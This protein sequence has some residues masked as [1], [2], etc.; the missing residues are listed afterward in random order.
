[1]KPHGVSGWDLPSH[2]AWWHGHLCRDVCVPGNNGFR[3]E[4]HW[5]TFRDTRCYGVNFDKIVL[6]W[7]KKKKERCWEKR[8]ILI[9]DYF[10]IYFT[11]FISFWKYAL[12]LHSRSASPA[13]LME[14][15]GSGGIQQTLHSTL[16]RSLSIFSTLALCDT[17]LS[18]QVP[19]WNQSRIR[20]MLSDRLLPRQSCWGLWLA[21]WDPTFVHIWDILRAVRTG[22]KSWHLSA[23]RHSGSLELSVLFW[24]LLWWCWLLKTMVW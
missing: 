7:E 11:L 1:M 6:S 20:K 17:C 3:K 10:L 21:R 22:R 14:H 23:L 8:N 19:L 18:I 4:R 15:W 16:Q 5:R 13:A 12:S 9:F 2:P 24:W